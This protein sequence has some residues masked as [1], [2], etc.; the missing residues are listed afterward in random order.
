MGTTGSATGTL[1]FTGVSTYSSDFQQIIQRAVAIA[2]QPVTALQNQVTANSDKRTTLVAMS[3]AVAAVGSDVAE[4]GALASSRGVSASSSDSSIVSVTNTGASAPGTYTV[5]NI[6]SL[7]TLASETSLNGY[8][9]NQTVSSS[10]TVNLMV[11]AKNYTLDLTGENQNNISGLASAINN[12]GAGVNATILTAGSENYLVVSANNTGATTLQLSDVQTPTDLVSNTG[13]GTETALQTYADADATPVSADGQFTL[14]VG[15]NNYNLSVTGNNNLNGLALA[16]NNAGAGVTATVTGSA[17]S[18]SLSI[19]AAGA[20]TIQLNA[21]PAA[22]LL[23]GTNQ[24]SDASFNLNGI[25]ITQSS[26]TVAGVI[27]G[28]S[29]TLQ[30]ETTDSVTL[31]LQSDGSQLSSALQ[32]LVTDYNT[33]IGQV[34]AQQGPSAG[35][36]GG[37][38]L[39][40]QISQDMQQLA[41]YWNPAS[42][43]NVRSLSDLGVTFNDSGQMSFDPTVVAGFSDSQLSDAFQYLGSSTTGL[44]AL[45]NNFTQLTDPITGLIVTEENGLTAENTSL[46][47]QITTLNTRVAQV[48]ASATAQAQQADSFVAQLQNEQ[49]TLDASIQSLNYVLFGKPTSASGA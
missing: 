44:G 18:Y 5:S 42:A 19:A 8:T 20:T 32:S 13:T 47:D 43:S 33:L 39:V 25:P 22:E 49:Y 28:V 6:S 16:I 11:G 1:Y 26:N 21:A 34:Q 30:S 35:P 12:A 17:G 45:A 38:L 2:Q 14:V 3:P 31:S 24:G 4:L 37:D 36:L 23:S 27:P 9:A 10:G 7:A 41:T 15:S 29:F 46:N 40:N 48:Q